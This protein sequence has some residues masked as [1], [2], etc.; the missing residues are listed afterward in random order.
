MSLLVI[1]SSS[2]LGQ[3][4]EQELEELYTWVDSIPLSR[5]KRNITRDFSDGVMVAEVVSHF[6]PK[7]IEIHNYSPANATPQKM[8]NWFL[9]NRKVF[10]KLRFE[11]SEDILRGIS[12]CKPG[13][14]E[15]VLAMLR[16][17]M[18]RVV[19]E[20]QQKVDRQAAENERPEA[21]QNSFRSQRKDVTG[22]NYMNP[23]TKSKSDQVPLLLLEEKEQEILAKDETIQILNAKIKRM[24]HLLHLKDI[25]IEDLQAR[26]E[27]SRPTGKRHQ[28]HTTAIV[29]AFMM[30]YIFLS[31]M[32]LIHLFA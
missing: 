11:L 6:L 18:E 13:V 30:F 21:D 22:L 32:W 31:V 24:E 23:Q 29:R 17:R 10:K 25:R 19:W 14:I 5:P 15:G 16:T 9:L 26:L 2:D 28:K 3:L 7:L 20:T 12:N 1:K 4:G 27:V 8:Q